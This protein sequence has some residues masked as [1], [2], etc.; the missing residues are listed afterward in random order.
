MS[1]VLNLAAALNHFAPQLDSACLSLREIKTPHKDLLS[2]AGALIRPDSLRCAIRKLNRAQLRRLTDLK[3]SAPLT[4]SDPLTQQLGA[5]G[6]LGVQAG[7]LKTL[8][9][10]TWQLER[11]QGES[12]GAVA[13]RPGA[14]ASDSVGGLA[15]ELAGGSAPPPHGE[16]S[17]SELPTAAPASQWWHAAALATTHCDTLTRLLHH[18]PV[19]LIAGKRASTKTPVGVKTLRA[20][21]KQLHLTQQLVG[22]YFE[23]LFNAGILSTRATQDR[24]TFA[25]VS[26]AG[27]NWLRLDLPERWS[28]LVATAAL[29][30]AAYNRAFPGTI[31]GAEESPLT[32]VPP[33]QYL[34]E[35][36]LAKPQTL[37]AYTALHDLLSALGCAL[38]TGYNPVFSHSLKTELSYLRSTAE[39]GAEVGTSSGA[40]AAA[41]SGAA[42]AASSDVEGPLIGGCADPPTNPIAVYGLDGL[43][44]QQQTRIYLQPDQTILCPGSASPALADTLWLLADPEQLELASTWR[45]SQ[46]SLGRAVAA[47]V[48]P[49]EILRRLS[50][51]SL[52]GVPQPLQ[53]TLAEMAAALPR[54]STNEGTGPAETAGSKQP[55]PLAEKLAGLGAIHRELLQL[56]TQKPGGD[57]ITNTLQLA[58]RG[59]IAVTVAVTSHG[60]DHSFTLVPRAVASGRLRGVDPQNEIERTIPLSAITAVT[61]SD[62]R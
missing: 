6:L 28:A 61:V 5:L 54:E 36:P 48:S 9:E 19:K 10:A 22:E 14:E 24:G 4:D 8:P 25:V 7:Q 51:I 50:E 2:L 12:A 30:T 27:R 38:E 58:A 29:Q 17:G 18:N 49:D 56:V 16:V 21:A 60:Q 20:F 59:S 52:T 34:A 57:T 41:S 32:V 43:A 42:A 1:S 11:L 55:T 62:H 31:A 45:I 35:H 46:E 44:P 15:G 39:A 47:G 53:F 33:A 13:S 23:L 26:P 3:T 40:A 37:T